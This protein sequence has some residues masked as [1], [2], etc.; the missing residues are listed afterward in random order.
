LPHSL[1]EKIEPQTD[2]DYFRKA[3]FW[4]VILAGLP[5]KRALACMQQVRTGDIFLPEP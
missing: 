1:R 4:G 5:L 3:R 2:A